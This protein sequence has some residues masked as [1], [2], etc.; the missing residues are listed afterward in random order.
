MSDH[1]A[2]F[3]L[4]ARLRARRVSAGGSI[5]RFRALS[6]KTSITIAA[7]SVASFQ[8]VRPRAATESPQYS[9]PPNIADLPKIPC[10]ILEKAVSKNEVLREIGDNLRCVLQTE[11]AMNSLAETIDSALQAAGSATEDR[12]RGIIAEF[13]ALNLLEEESLAAVATVIAA[14]ACARHARHKA[15]YLDAVRT[16][17]LEIAAALVPPPPRVRFAVELERVAEGADLLIAGSD[18]LVALMAAQEIRTQDR[19]V[20]ELALVSRLLGRNDANTI[21]RALGAVAGAVAAAAFRSGALVLVPLRDGTPS[22][23]RGTD[24]ALLEPRGCA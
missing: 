2:I 15:I 8:P 10:D 16:W 12:L 9:P 1:G 13:D 22:T 5:R 17:S 23:D 7:A 11:G 14:T 19:L 21:H 18:S 4:P 6:V 24:L 3:V 20:T